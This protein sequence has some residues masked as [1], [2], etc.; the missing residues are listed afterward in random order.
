M[1]NISLNDPCPAPFE[2]MLPLLQN[3]K[4]T[5]SGYSARCPAH[6]DHESS[7]SLGQ[8]DDGK[9]LLNC[10]AGCEVEDIVA[11]IG[12]RMSDLSPRHGAGVLSP[13]NTLQPRNPSNQSVEKIGESG[14]QPT[15]DLPSKSAQ[16]LQSENGITLEKYAE[17]KHLPIAFLKELGL[18]DFSYQG[19]PAVRIPY[20]DEKEREVAIRFRI[21][22][23]KSEKADNRFRW[24]SGAK[25]T[26]YGLWRIALTT[27]SE[28][29]VLVEGESDCQ[30]LW[31]HEI[32]ALGIP[33]AGNWDENRYA[34]VLDKFSSIFVVIE[35]DKGGEAVKKW[36]AASQIRSRVRLVTLGE[37]KDPSDLFLADP[38]KFKTRW[39][40]KIEASIPWADLSKAEAETRRKEAWETC[41]ELA[42]EPRI[43]ER[44]IEEFSKLGVVG[45]NK[46]A[47]I[48]Y[49]ALTS[50]VLERPVS[51][52][53]KGPSSGGKSF[54]TEKVLSFFPPSAYYVLTAM[55][56][57]A[58]AYLE[59]SLVHRF[60]VICEAPG[61]QGEM[62]TYMTRSLLS[63]GR[64]RYASVE[65]TKDGLKPTL[66]EREGPTGLLLTTT[67][68]S[69]HPENETRMLSLTVSDTQEQT[70]NI[71]LAMAKEVPP[72]TINVEP[73]H[74]LQTW[75]A[76]GTARVKIPYAKVLAES[77]PAVAVRLRRD[78]RTVLNLIKSH[79]L[80]HQV[81]REKGPGGEIIADFEDYAAVY[82]VMADML[83][84]GV[85]VSVS[86]ATQEAVKAV[87]DIL[88]GG[89]EEGTVVMVA[90]KLQLDKST[91]LRRVRAAIE[92]GFIKNLEDRK[93]RPARLV[94]GDPLP[95]DPSIL[96]S[97][98]ELKRQYLATK[99]TPLQPPDEP[100]NDEM[101]DS[102]GNG[103]RV[104][105]K[106]AT[107]PSAPM[108]GE[109]INLYGGIL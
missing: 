10:F 18:Q 35:P 30:T 25:P 9:V 39:R 82:E 6:N 71:I 79:A 45:E 88:Q 15:P 22:L 16:S 20:F 81:N 78:F 66:I 92:A 95:D 90:K 51:V 48:L 99:E 8:G 54:I 57:K 63:E 24:K 68:L 33:G 105:P 55:S 98:D 31:H 97:P 21:G 50:R 52:G 91:A 102:Y 86:A 44:L 84:I 42:A 12:M 11:K 1:N 106:R 47:K 75:I 58:L 17:A 89:E 14:I 108:P 53:V 36:L 2:K 94:I 37:H 13:R 29:V 104:S 72:D 40:E 19:S 87:E 101:S 7:L 65:K 103:C 49:L 83:A 41:K 70:K 85:G 67:A 74:A 3:V 76:D 93:A 27:E 80:L 77:M 73:W 32:P 28:Y 43:L 26:L 5:R 64:I 62:A 46:I 59:E 96:P 61:I 100:K 109:G 56:D 38:E 4:Q 107:S 23:K 34:P 60:L 69:L